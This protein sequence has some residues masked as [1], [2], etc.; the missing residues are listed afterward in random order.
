MRFR[1]IKL[2]ATYLLRG[3]WLHRLRHTLKFL[4]LNGLYKVCMNGE[5]GTHGELMKFIHVT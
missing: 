2:G 5:A 3:N 1:N 4:I